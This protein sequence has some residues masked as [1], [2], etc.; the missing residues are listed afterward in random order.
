MSSPDVPIR[1][2]DREY[3][4]VTDPRSNHYGKV[5]II[6]RWDLRTGEAYILLAGEIKVLAFDRDSIEPASLQQYADALG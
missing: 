3:A 4:T 6:T 5:G 2:C 1:P